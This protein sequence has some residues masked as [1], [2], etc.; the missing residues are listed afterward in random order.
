MT[1]GLMFFPLLVAAIELLRS[2]HGLSRIAY[3][4]IDAHHGDGVFYAFESDPAVIF[5]DLNA[6]FTGFTMDETMPLATL[7][8]RMAAHVAA[9]TGLL[10]P[11]LR[12]GRAG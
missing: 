5:A 2:R 7:T 10:A 1:I 6:M 8:G 3:V 12:L 4:D 11:P 9:L